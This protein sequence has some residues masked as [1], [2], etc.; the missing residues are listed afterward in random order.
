VPVVSAG[1]RVAVLSDVHGNA[2]AFEAV[3]EEVAEAEPD[4]VVCGGD[5]TWGP[6]PEETRVLAEGIEQPVRSTCAATRS[7]RSKRQTLGSKAR[8]KS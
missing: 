4:L 5:L 3:L 7:E 6:L 8:A 1:S 2:V